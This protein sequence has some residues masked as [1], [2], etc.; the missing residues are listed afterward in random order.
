MDDEW[1]EGWTL[2]GFTFTLFWNFK[3]IQT[4]IDRFRQQTNFCCY[5]NVSFVAHMHFEFVKKF[6]KFNN[7]I[8]KPRIFC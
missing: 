1:F 8:K 5:E 2:G 4:E 7:I 3:K 6:Q